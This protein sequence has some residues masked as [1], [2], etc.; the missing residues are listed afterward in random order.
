MLN[1]TIP[2]QFY[3]IPMIKSTAQNFQMFQIC[4]SK[5][6]NK[7]LLLLSFSS[8]LCVTTKLFSEKTLFSPN[9]LC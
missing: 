1:L 4:P 8:I 5:Q 7:L 2:E 9:S 3:A 6:P